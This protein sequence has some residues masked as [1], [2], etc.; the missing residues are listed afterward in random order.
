MTQNQD[1]EKKKKQ[2][3]QKKKKTQKNQQTGVNSGSRE[4]FFYKTPAMLLIVKFDLSLV[5]DRE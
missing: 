1:N 3:K 5:R 2:R 4:V